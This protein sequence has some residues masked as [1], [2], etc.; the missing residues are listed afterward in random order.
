[1]PR[2]TTKRPTRRQPQLRLH[3]RSQRTYVTLS[4]QTF[5]CGAVDDPTRF[6]RFAQQVQAWEERDRQPLEHD[7]AVADEL[8]VS[9]LCDR[10]LEHLR[11][12]KRDGCLAAKVGGN[13]VHNALE[14]L[15]RIARST[16]R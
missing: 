10:D 14:T 7:E 3:K 2:K 16:P 8:L 13:R 6:A 9:Q 4:G 15:R 11:R 12:R 5:W 1:M